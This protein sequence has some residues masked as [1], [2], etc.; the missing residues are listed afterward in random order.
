MNTDFCHIYK[1][2]RKLFKINNFIL[3][4]APRALATLIPKILFVIKSILPYRF[5]N[6]AQVR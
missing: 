1:T 3:F 2:L 5:V 4:R 6:M